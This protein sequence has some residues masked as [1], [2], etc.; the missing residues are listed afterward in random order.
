MKKMRFLYTTVLLLCAAFAL[1]VLVSCGDS[2]NGLPKL[3]KI[4]VTEERYYQ[5]EK[6]K[7]YTYIYPSE[8]PSGNPVMLSAVITVGDNVTETNPAKA[9]ILYNHATIYGADECPSKSDLTEQRT[10]AGYG[11]SVITISPDYYGFGNTEDKN[12]AY[13]I[14]SVNAQ[15]AVDALLAAK[16]LL[17]HLGYSYYGNK[18]F[19]VGYS[20]GGQTAM[21]VV[22]LVRQKYPE[23]NLTRTF[24]GAG[25]YD[26]TA[27]Y[28]DF[29][30]SKT[31]DL[32]STVV[33]VFLSYN[34]FY[35]LGIK[36]EELFKGE[37]LLNID[38]WFLSKK[39]SLNDIE[40]LIGTKDLTSL[41]TA[42]A[43]DKTSEIGKKFQEAFKKDAVTQ[44]WTPQADESIYLFHC[45]NDETVPVSTTEKLVEFL[46]ENG[47]VESTDASQGVYVHFDETAG[48]PYHQ[49]AAVTFISAAGMQLMKLLMSN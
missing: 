22:K 37:L 28:D 10:I 39:K 21:A 49:N 15:G 8:D 7:A 6:M 46:K 38:S 29:I 41:C 47:V 30:Q 35:N 48:K 45:K 16:K 33:N 11:F 32:P 26:I 12:Q 1:T 23:I 3:G 42:A 13:C 36:N 40:S 4:K 24:A 5:A 9:L 31:S 44:G 34:E 2:S 43:L 18:L 14:G 25:P 20:Q 17:P 19:N 27:V